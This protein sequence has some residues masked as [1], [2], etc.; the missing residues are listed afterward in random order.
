MSSEVLLLALQ[1]LATS[2]CTAQGEVVAAHDAQLAPDCVE[3]GKWADHQ[4]VDLKPGGWIE[5]TLGDRYAL[6]ANPTDAPR[7]LELRAPFPPVTRPALVC[8]ER[9]DGGSTC[10][11]VDD[12][13]GVFCHTHPRPRAPETTST[14]ATP[15]TP[16]ARRPRA[17]AKRASLF[18]LDF[19][20]ND[21]SAQEARVLTRLTT[22]ELGRLHGLDVSSGDEVRELLATEAKRQRQGCADDSCLAQVAG[23]LGARWLVTG[24]VGRVGR[25]TRL[26]VALIDTRS[27]EVVT[28]AA[29]DGEDTLGLSRRLA[30]VA[31]NLM[32]PIRGGD[33][34]AIE[35]AR[36]GRRMA[37]ADAAWASAVTG[38]GAAAGL[39][40]CAALPAV[41]CTALLFPV[42]IVPTGFALTPFSM[43]LCSPSLWIAP[44]TAFAAGGGVS[45]AADWLFDAELG[46]LRALTT[47]GAAAGCAAGG[48]FIGGTLAEMALTGANLR[49]MPIEQQHL[50]G[51]A[52]AAVV[53]GTAIVGTGAV[54][55][56]VYDFGIGLYGDEPARDDDV[57][58]ART[59]AAR[60]AVER[61]QAY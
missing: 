33:E 45:L 44:L 13:E 5:L 56:V 61:P 17:A 38:A 43:C 50:V 53:I 42:L 59:E 10:A 46:W 11:P 39:L 3:A 24:A 27:G 58:S 41:G 40:L 34:R 14:P 1:L 60:A 16:P 28:R 7:A 18:V 52:T 37:D 32:R 57:E 19:A 35:P 47:A 51:G 36:F 20:G 22:A 31:H 4:R 23:A 54:A 8:R 21:V 9:P 48:L 26:E 55:G 15:T 25:A 6:C 29:A 12:S 2:G 30:A 49:A